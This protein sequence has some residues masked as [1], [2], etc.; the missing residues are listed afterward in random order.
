MKQEVHN[1][2][3][4]IH[5]R[6][7]A[8][9][10]S[11]ETRRSIQEILSEMVSSLRDGVVDFQDPCCIFCGSR[12]SHITSTKRGDYSILRSHKCMF[13][14]MPFRSQEKLPVR[15]TDEVPATIAKPKRKTYSKKRGG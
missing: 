6:R 13:C 10:I 11:R 8:T 7:V 1:T 15:N 2:M 5:M 9:T 12:Q 3:L 4:S 14:G